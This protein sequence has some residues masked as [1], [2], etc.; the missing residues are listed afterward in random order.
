[1]PWFTDEQKGPRVFA[2]LSPDESAW[3]PEVDRDAV[4]LRV[5]DALPR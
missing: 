2:F 1:M 5:R 3:L 4:A